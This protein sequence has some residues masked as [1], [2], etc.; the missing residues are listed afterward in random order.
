MC[1]HSGLMNSSVVD[2]IM[3]SF[4]HCDD[5]L[6]KR[7]SLQA[8]DATFSWSREEKGCDIAELGI[9]RYIT[10]TSEGVT[11]EILPGT[12]AFLLWTLRVRAFRHQHHLLRMRYAF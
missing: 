8:K 9:A 12:S 7:I 1:E 11:R 3:A 2:R 5:L 4:A 10:V 6:L